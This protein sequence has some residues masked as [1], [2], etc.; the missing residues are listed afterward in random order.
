MRTAPAA[1]NNSASVGDA[2]IY[3][4]SNTGLESYRATLVAA[5]P[6]DDKF[7]LSF[8]A[9]AALNI[10]AGDKVRAVPLSVSDRH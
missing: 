6:V 8:E 5:T 7:P 2:V 4:V 10:N 3:L 9:A 1:V